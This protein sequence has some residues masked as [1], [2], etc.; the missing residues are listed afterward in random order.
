MT[1][2]STEYKLLTLI[3]SKMGILD[4]CPCLLS[5]NGVC[6][7]IAVDA[8]RT[9]KYFKGLLS[10]WKQCLPLGEGCDVSF[11]LWGHKIWE[12]IFMV[13]RVYNKNCVPTNTYEF[14]K[15]CYLQFKEKQDYVGPLDDSLQPFQEIKGSDVPIVLVCALREL[16]EVLMEISE[17]VNSPTEERINAS[18]LKWQESYNQHYRHDCKT[19]YNKWIIGFSHRTRKKHIQERMKKEL[20]TFRSIFRNED[21]FEQVFDTEQNSIDYDGLSRFLFTHVDRFGVSHS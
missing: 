13:Q 16:N 7:S 12:M 21:E 18:F 5:L 3:E 8:C 15:D 2:I 14:E 10:D 19:A 20:E 17:F 6:L 9:T 4:I 1:A 11:E